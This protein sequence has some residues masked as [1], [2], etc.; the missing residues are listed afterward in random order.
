M[1]F[2]LIGSNISYTLTETF[3]YNLI[4]LV[5]NSNRCLVNIIITII[6]II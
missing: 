2:V 4:I 5:V 3:D 6:I 1:T